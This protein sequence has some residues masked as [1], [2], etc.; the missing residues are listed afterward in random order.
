MKLI[1]LVISITRLVCQLTSLQYLSVARGGSS[2]LTKRILS[3]IRQQR[4]LGMR[5]I[6]ST[7]GKYRIIFVFQYLNLLLQNQRYFHQ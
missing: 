5:V 2:D 7:Q 1:K 4:H 3:I 6:I